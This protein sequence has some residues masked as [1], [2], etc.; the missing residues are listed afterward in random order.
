MDRNPVEQKAATV[1]EVARAVGYS[2]PVGFS[3]AFKR[4]GA[5]NPN[6]F[7][8]TVASALPR[9]ERPITVRSLPARK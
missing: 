1:A 2:D 8:R 4:I 7:R 9:A 5:V 6:T 3:A